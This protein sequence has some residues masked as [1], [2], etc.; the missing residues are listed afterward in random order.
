MCFPVGA[1]EVRDVSMLRHMRCLM[2]F[3]AEV[4]LCT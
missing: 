3:H 2:C 1:R 4:N